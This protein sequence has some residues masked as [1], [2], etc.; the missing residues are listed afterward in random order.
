MK[1]KK[2]EGKNGKEEVEYDNKERWKWIKQI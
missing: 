1:K 2:M